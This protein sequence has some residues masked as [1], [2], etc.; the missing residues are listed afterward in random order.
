MKKLF[1]GLVLIAVVSSCQINNRRYTRGFQI[2]WRIG[3]MSSSKITSNRKG[4][5]NIANRESDHNQSI[6]MPSLVTMKNEQALIPMMISGKFA[7]QILAAEISQ[8]ETISENKFPELRHQIN[9]VIQDYTAQNPIK[10]ANHSANQNGNGSGTMVLAVLSLIFAI[11]GFVLLISEDVFMYGTASA[12]LL[13]AI[14]ALGRHNKQERGRGL[15]VIMLFV[16]LG[17]I[18][19]WWSM[20]SALF[21]M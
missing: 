21:P 15:A 9:D 20:V 6:P 11:A 10:C 14:L 3:K 16:S 12:S 5:T 8:L 4:E 2:E 1:F 17:L 7:P 19:A 13:L 18:I